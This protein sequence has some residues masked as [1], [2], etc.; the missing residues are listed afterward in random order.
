MET[1]GNVSTRH[2]GRV[3]AV[4]AAA[5]VLA[6]SLGACGAGGS[7]S[8]PAGSGA[9]DGSASGGLPAT[10]HEHA[11]REGHAF[12]FGDFEVLKGWRIGSDSVLGQRTVDNMRVKDVSGGRHIFMMVVRLYGSG[13]RKVG[14]ITCSTEG[15]AHKVG[16]TPKG[17]ICVP[18][19]GSKQKFTKITVATVV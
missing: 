12:R 19:K 3:A 17:V 15:L 8:G 1:R 16:P 9:S 6:M 14:E 7:G 5:G 10:V 2:L 11:V 13:D 4:A 18:E